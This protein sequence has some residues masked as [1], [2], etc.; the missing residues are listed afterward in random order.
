MNS[1]R[2]LWSLIPSIRTA[3]VGNRV[4]MPMYMARNFSLSQEDVQKRVTSVIKNFHKVNPNVQITENTHFINDLGIDSLD[5]VELLMAFEDEFSIEIP[6]KDV[7]NIHT[8]G[9]AIKYFMVPL[10]LVTPI[11]TILDPSER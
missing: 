9:Q 11:N 2:F 8:A 1:G 5:E 10:L 3:Q 7:E 4:V 6:D